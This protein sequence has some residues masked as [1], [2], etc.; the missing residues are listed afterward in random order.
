MHYLRWYRGSSLGGPEQR[1]YAT[2]GE[3]LRARTIVT[4]AGCHLWQGFIDPAGYGHIGTGNRVQTVHRVAWELVN[5]PIPDGLE[6]DHLC[7]VRSCV[8]PAHLEPVTPKENY[9]RSTAREGQ[10]RRAAGVTH[11]PQ[12]HPYNEAN[13]YRRDNKRKCRACHR[14]VERIKYRRLN[15]LAG[16][17]QDRTSGGTW[18][19]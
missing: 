3:A 7:R 9:A 12:G 6:L 5:G 19:G 2:P 13:T 8:N 1:Q 4:E 11:C 18:N 15:G 10:A 14:A 17:G 16:P